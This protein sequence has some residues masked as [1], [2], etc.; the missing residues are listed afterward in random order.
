MPES[1]PYLTCRFVYHIY[2]FSSDEP[3]IWHYSPNLSSALISLHQAHSESISICAWFNFKNKSRKWACLFQ[4][5][6][7]V[8]L[9]HVTLLLTDMWQ[10][11]HANPRPDWNHMIA[12]TSPVYAK[13][14]TWITGLIPP[15]VNHPNMDKPTWM[16][17]HFFQCIYHCHGPIV[18]HWA[19]L[20]WMPH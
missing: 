19:P 13:W 16:S 10:Q 2:C 4:E 17:H 3:S 7:F 9:H 14:A 12:H 6:V 18:H 20:E 5:S 11:P 1:K 15:S 8:S